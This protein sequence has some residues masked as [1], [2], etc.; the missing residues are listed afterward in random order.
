MLNIQAVLKDEVNPEQDN[1]EE[2]EILTNEVFAQRHLPFE[3]KEKMRWSFWGK[4]HCRHSLRSGTRLSGSVGELRT[5]GE[6]SSV[7]W[8]FTQLDTDQQLSSEECLPQAPWERR[9]FP[10]DD[11]EET[12][13]SSDVLQWCS[14]ST[15]TLSSS[16]S[17]N[18]DASMIQSIHT[19]PPSGGHYM[20][21]TNSGS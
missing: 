9:V 11:D 19:T 7:E 21:C 17:L 18:S 15:C 6:D 20:D 2:I 5:S 4:Q 16:T 13:L 1:H 14:D 12:A 10:L 3:Q 8:S